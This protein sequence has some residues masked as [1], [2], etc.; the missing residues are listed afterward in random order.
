MNI[1]FT[2][3]QSGRQNAVNG[4]QMPSYR[5]RLNQRLTPIDHQGS[6]K[7]LAEMEAYKID[8][9][10][11]EADGFRLNFIHQ[12]KDGNDGDNFCPQENKARFE[13]LHSEIMENYKGDE[14]EKRLVALDLAVAFVD[15]LQ[16]QHRLQNDIIRQDII[17]Q[18]MDGSDVFAR[19]EQMHAEI[20]EGYKGDDLSR[21]LAFLD[22][23]FRHAALYHA[24]TQ[25]LN[26]M[27]MSG[28]A[29]SLPTS[30]DRSE[31]I[32]WMITSTNIQNHVNQTF[33]AAMDFFRANGSFEGF[34]DTAAANIPGQLSFNDILIITGDRLETADDSDLSESGRDFL[35][36]IMNRDF[37]DMPTVAGQR[38]SNGIEVV[39]RNPTMGGFLDPSLSAATNEDHFAHIEAQFTW[40]L[41]ETFTFMG[42]DLGFEEFKVMRMYLESRFE[43]DELA[44]RLQAL[45]NGFLRAGEEIAR[46]ISENLVRLSPHYTMEQEDMTLTKLQTDTNARI[47][48]EANRLMEHISGM[49]RAALEFFNENG[50]FD[51]FMDTSAA[52]QPGMPSMRDV[53]RLPVRFDPERPPSINSVINTPGLS[54]AGRGFLERF[55]EI[56][57]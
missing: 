47:R 3:P 10:L 30:G 32:A 19:F 31:S 40:I 53:E 52:N 25:A 6:L 17:Q 24:R 55:F 8:G 45:E 4:R 29:G 33:H 38:W 49:F 43:G 36:G 35:Y 5:T 28:I 14:Q 46:M 9:S 18:L 44:A 16:T 2:M 20:T 48:A 42:L 41:L 39:N 12:L 11:L 54:D 34:A 21:R 57:P 56:E 13:R 1:Q 27:N 26:I 37:L 51:G 50:S 7:A 22:E 23:A 15:N